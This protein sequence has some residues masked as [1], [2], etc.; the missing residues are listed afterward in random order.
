MSVV[1]S[2]LTR[3]G[4]R[5]LPA[6][7]AVR[8]TTVGAVHAARASGLLAGAAGEAALEAEHGAGDLVAHRGLAL[9][10]VNDGAAAAGEETTP[11]R[12]GTGVLTVSSGG[13]GR[14]VGGTG[15]LTAAGEETA[16]GARGLGG[17]V[18]GAAGLAG[19]EDGH[20]GGLG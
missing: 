9:L 19:A 14:G 4:L 13:G 17:G 12:G 2:G 18:A 5:C 16:V 11:G 7:S 8:A 3:A 10:M 6:A 1:V 20:F 15:G